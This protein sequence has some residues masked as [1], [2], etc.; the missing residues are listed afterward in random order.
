[1]R[2]LSKFEEANVK[3]LMKFKGMTREKA[4][5]ALGLGDNV[6]GDSAGEFHVFVGRDF[7]PVSP[8]E[9]FSDP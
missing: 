2:K 5:C 8:D 6:E 1:M 7:T 4:M 3:T 9:F